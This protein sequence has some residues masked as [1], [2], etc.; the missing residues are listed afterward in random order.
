MAVYL[1]SYDLNKQEKNYTKIISA[2]KLIDPSTYHVLKSQ[3]LISSQ[4]LAAEI[5]ERLCR[6]IDKDD[7]LLITEIRGNYAG[8]LGN[9]DDL[10]AWI[11]T[12]FK[13]Q[14]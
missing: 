9:S 6:Y 10:S 4:L 1:I 11:K 3:W 12:R 5:N 2:I 7:D 8:Y 14:N 13:D